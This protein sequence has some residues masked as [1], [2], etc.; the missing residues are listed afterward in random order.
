M[1]APPPGL[2]GPGL[3]LWI[4]LTDSYEFRP[5]E[6]VLLRQVAET[7]TLLD[8]LERESLT[9]DTVVRGSQGQPVA[10]PILQE[11][12]AHRATLTTMLR[13]LALPDLDDDDAS[14]A[15]R[16]RSVASIR[17]SKAANARWSRS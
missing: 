9:A 5:D 11:L 4:E 6:L 16:Y 2:T 1:P 14:D 7:T 15:P 13:A 17:A 8:R 12:R 10:S 3:S